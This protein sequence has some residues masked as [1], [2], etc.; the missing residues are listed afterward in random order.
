MQARGLGA[1][2]L[3]HQRSLENGVPGGQVHGPQ[4]SASGGGSGSGLDVVLGPWGAQGPVERDA[5]RLEEA[6]TAGNGAVR[7]GGPWQVSEELSA[8]ELGALSR[9]WEQSSGEH[10]P[11]EADLTKP[12]QTSHLECVRGVLWV[13]SRIPFACHF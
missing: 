12:L 10:G 11:R 4:P 9:G 1:A 13:R 6:G 3:G 7:Q 5:V 2:L 8:R